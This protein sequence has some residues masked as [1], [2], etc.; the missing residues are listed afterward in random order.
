MLERVSTN[1]VISRQ[2][3]G[4]ELYT[5]WANHDYWPSSFLI[6]LTLGSFGLTTLLASHILFNDGSLPHF[7]NILPP[8]TEE[9]PALISAH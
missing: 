5:F 1:M 6:D 3:L 9:S 4:S 8:I 7:S 2:I